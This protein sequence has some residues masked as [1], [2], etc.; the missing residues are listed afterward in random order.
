MYTFSCFRYC[1][2]PIKTKV[3]LRQNFLYVKKRKKKN[4]SVAPLNAQD[5][6]DFQ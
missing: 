4:L 1:I 5:P 3:I 2:Y 6:L